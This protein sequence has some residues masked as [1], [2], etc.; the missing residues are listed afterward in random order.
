[1]TNEN[2]TKHRGSQI[3]LPFLLVAAFL[4][5]PARSATGVHQTAIVI[6]S[7]SDFLDRSAIDGSGLTDDPPGAQTTLEKLQQGA[8]DAQ[9]FSVF[10]PPAFKDY[11]YKKRTDELIARLKED[12][13]RNPAHIELVRNTTGIIAIANSGKVAAL[14]GI[15]G[16]HSIEDSI[17]H[18][19]HFYA[20]GVRYLTLTWSNTNEW[21]DSSSDTPRWGG[22]STKGREIVH[23]MNRLGMMVDISHVSD[24]T[25]WDVIETTKSP[26]IA[27]HSSARALADHPRNMSDSMIKAMAANGG[28]IQVN[29]YSRYVDTSFLKEFKQARAAAKDRFSVIE[30]KYA[31]DPI[32]LDKHLWSLEKELESGLIPPTVHQVVDHIEHIIQLVGP[33]Y[34]GLG[35]DFDGMGAPPSGLE[36]IGKLS[37]ITEDLLSRGYSNEVVK[38]VLG[39][40]LLRVMSENER[41]AR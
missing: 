29:F 26:I 24:E 31:D 13:A 20:Q 18:L 34:V 40:N 38:K 10:V 19:R 9:F 5:I 8:V 17:D 27:S 30:K 22:L 3:V 35:S 16:G 28:V 12:I 6:D 2:S 32:E 33:D 14:M 11:G 4:C 1:M 37:S 21:A 7:H 39:G 41:L 23:E 36:H 15:E 25:F